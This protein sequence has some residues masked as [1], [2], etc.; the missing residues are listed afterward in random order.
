MTCKD[1]HKMMD[2][3]DKGC[4]DIG[5]MGDF[6]RHVQQCSDCQE[7]YEIYNIVKYALVNDD[8]KMNEL[9]NSRP[10]EERRYISTYDFKGLVLYRIG[11]ACKI[12]ETYERNQNY[13][14][15]LFVIAEFSVTL[16][17]VFY[18]FGDFFF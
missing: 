9:V 17:A 16:M 3:F 4:L 15:M 11:R 2:A 12:A 6:A 7:E 1:Y 5:E 8:D 13:H 18:L 14:K 10:K